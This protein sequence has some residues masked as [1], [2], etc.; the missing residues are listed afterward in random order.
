MGMGSAIGGLIGA[1][2][3]GSIMNSGKNRAAGAI[4]DGT[5][6]LTAGNQQQRQDF[7]PYMEAGTQGLDMYQ[8]LLAGG[9]P[10]TMPTASKAFEF[11]AFKDPSAQYAIQSSND[12][13]LAAGLAGGN[14]GGGLS[15]AIT[16]NTQQK[17]LDAYGNAYQRYLAQNQQDFGQGQQNFQNQTGN[18]QTMLSGANNLAGIGLNAAGTT[19]GNS[20]GYNQAANQNYNNMASLYYGN[21]QNQANN[22]GN[23]L[24]G[25]FSGVS[26]MMIPGMG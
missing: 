10:A 13:L 7:M 6:L 15:R 11:D 17:A 18:W 5:D 21:A 26:S 16:A 25:A 24:S 20:M 1:G 14:A 9:N 22:W 19:A 12:A 3:A 4:Q 23:A 8:N 2:V